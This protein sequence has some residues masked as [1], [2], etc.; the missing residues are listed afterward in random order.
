[1]KRGYHRSS[2]TARRSGVRIA[3]RPSRFLVVPGSSRTLPGRE[4]HPGP[5]Q[6][7]QFALDAPTVGVGEAGDGLQVALPDAAAMGRRGG[8]TVAAEEM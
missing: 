5:R 3:V 8:E 1:V 6:A 7:E 2:K 4:V